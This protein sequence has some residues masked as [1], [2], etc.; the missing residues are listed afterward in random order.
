MATK[1]AFPTSSV[2]ALKLRVTSLII[3]RAN[4]FFIK[5]N[6]W[7]LGEREKEAKQFYFENEKGKERKK[8]SLKLF[9]KGSKWK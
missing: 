6:V 5:R 7:R 2:V 3:S 1:E 9:L 4:I 8:N